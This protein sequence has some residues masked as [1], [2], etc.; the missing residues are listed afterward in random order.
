MQHHK[1]ALIQQTFRVI[2]SPSRGPFSLSNATSQVQA[3]CISVYA[4]RTSCSPT[5]SCLAT[6]YGY[7]HNSQNVR[8]HRPP[9]GRWSHSNSVGVDSAKI[10][11]RLLLKNFQNNVGGSSDSFPPRINTLPAAAPNSPSSSSLSDQSK[12]SFSNSAQTSLI[13]SEKLP[14]DSFSLVITTFLSQDKPIFSPRLTSQAASRLYASSF[15]AK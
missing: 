7:P 6:L 3:H 10:L 9:Q 8:E 11:Q 2:V 13:T 5:R 4:H 1:S 14:S 15:K 12:F